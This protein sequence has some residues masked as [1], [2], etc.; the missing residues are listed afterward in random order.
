MTREHTNIWHLSQQHGDIDSRPVQ[1]VDGWNPTQP[2]GTVP[3]INDG[4]IEHPTNVQIISGTV[5]VHYLG[6]M[7][8]DGADPWP[9]RSGRYLM[10]TEKRGPAFDGKL[11]AEGF[12]AITGREPQ[13]DDLDRVNCAQAGQIG[14]GSCGLCRTC[15]KPRFVCGGEEFPHAQLVKDQLVQSLKAQA[16]TE[17]GKVLNA[18]GMPRQCFQDV[19]PAWMRLLKALGVTL[20]IYRQRPRENWAWPEMREAVVIALC[21]SEQI[22]TP[23]GREQ[24]GT[25]DALLRGYALECAL[26]IESRTAQDYGDTATYA[27]YVSQA[28]DYRLFSEGRES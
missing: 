22:D 7:R 9:V 18:L 26:A 3:T 23:A 21:Y 6:V 10:H 20:P 28:R 24:W 25:A 27:I 4:S 12:K 19:M 17:A 8:S 1:S 13:Q 16:L 5:P 15:G 11:T 2:D 14:H